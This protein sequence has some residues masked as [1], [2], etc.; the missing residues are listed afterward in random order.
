[1]E[2]QWLTANQAAEWL[3]CSVHTIYRWIH[4]THDGTAAKPL[5]LKPRSDNMRGRGKSWLI[6][7]Q[8]LLVADGSSGRRRLY[9]KKDPGSSKAAL[10]TG[11]HVEEDRRAEVQADRK[12]WV[13]GWVT[14][15]KPLDKV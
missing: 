5:L 13:E 4:E 11:C 6:G 9:V 2:E 14:E 15:G 12:R 1:M 3:G 8:S 7:S 10:T